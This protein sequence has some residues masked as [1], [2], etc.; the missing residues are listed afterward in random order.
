MS[1]AM[2]YQMIDFDTH[3]YETMDC[4]T[5]FMPKDKLDSAVQPVTL[6]SG[7]TVLLANHRVVNALENH[8]DKAYVPGSLAEMLRQ[9]SQGDSADAERFF[10]DM[11]DEYLDRDARL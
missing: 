7:E 9:R 6:A 5:R 3:S 8:L 4:F 11:R 1:E 10:E 2:S